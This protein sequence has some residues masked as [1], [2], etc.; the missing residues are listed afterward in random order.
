M[1]S[2]HSGHPTLGA[3]VTQKLLLEVGGGSQEGPPASLL[4]TLANAQVAGR[5]PALL[6]F[7]GACS[8]THL[9]DT[10]MG[11]SLGGQHGPG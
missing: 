6:L 10:S 8:K 1:A 11:V 7:K 3:P 9:T 2:P 5:V 4:P